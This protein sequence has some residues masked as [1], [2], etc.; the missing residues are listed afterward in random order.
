MFEFRS[1]HDVTMEVDFAPVGRRQEAVSLVEKAARDSP[2]LMLVP[3]LGVIA[4]HAHVILQ[5]AP[6]RIEGIP[7]GDV[8]VLV[9][10]MLG[11]TTN[12][13]QLFARDLDVETHVKQVPL[14]V[15]L[16]RRLDDGAD[17]HDVVVELFELRRFFANVRLDCG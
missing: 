14:V 8:Y 3:V 17:A 10:V 12:H 6:G 13:H 1:V 2:D 5:H 16:M 15:L 7:N 9:R 4:Y 11:R